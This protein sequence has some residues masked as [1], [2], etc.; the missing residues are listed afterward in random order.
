[1]IELQEIGGRELVADFAEKP[2]TI[3]RA[4]VRALNRSIIS[5]R[6]AMVRLIGGDT[7]LRSKDVRDAIPVHEATMERP[8]AYIAA[9]MKRMP[10]GDFRARGPHGAT[11]TNPVPSRGLGRGVSYRIGRSSG[12]VENAFFAKMRSGHVGV[13]KR[14]GSLKA[15]QHGPSASARKSRG[16]WSPNLPITELH[17][18]SLGHVFRKHRPAGIARVREVFEANLDHELKFQKSQ[19]PVSDGDA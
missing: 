11:S 19:P 7:G 4:I 15:G 18:P 6:T 3:T 9:S 12:R 14:V 1:V 5:G 8:D 10:L 2:Q 17:G 13:F 16:A